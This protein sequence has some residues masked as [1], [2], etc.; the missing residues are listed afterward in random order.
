MVA[1]GVPQ[2]E[3]VTRHWSSASV[4]ILAW[5]VISPRRLA[6]LFHFTTPLSAA[7]G[8]IT[9]KINIQTNIDQDWS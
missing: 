1:G 2:I 5:V 7:L 6:R 8:G 3:G 4:D 9:I